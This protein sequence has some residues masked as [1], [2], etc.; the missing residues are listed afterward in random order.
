MMAPDLACRHDNRLP[1][2]HPA[3]AAL[4]LTFLLLGC[5]VLVPV[6]SVEDG[7]L[8]TVPASR[9]MS[10]TDIILHP[11]RYY[12][13]THEGGEV[14]YQD[15]NRCSAPRGS[16]IPGEEAW[17]LHLRMKDGLL[18]FRDG[19]VVTVTT[20]QELVFFLPEGEDLEYSPEEKGLYQD[21]KGSYKI[22]VQVL[23]TPPHADFSRSVRLQGR[24]PSSYC[25]KGLEPQLEFMKTLGANSITLEILMDIAGSSLTPDPET[26]SY[27]C[28]VD[29]T[30]R[31]HRMGLKVTWQIKYS[32]LDFPDTESF[33]PP[34][35]DG[36]NQFFRNLEIG[37][38]AWADLAGM[39]K[40]ETLIPA[41]G[42]TLLTRDE[43]LR[44]R[45]LRIFIG[46]HARFFGGLVYEASPHELE[47]L[48]PEFW[49]ACCD[50][51]GVR[52]DFALS[53]A[54]LPRHQDLVDA[55]SLPVSR[56]EDLFE[57]T[58]LRI[59]MID[60]PGYP[61]AP[62]CASAPRGV[63]GQEL[64]EDCQPIAY[65]ALFQTL[66][67]MAGVSIAG[68]IIK[69]INLPGERRSPFS[70]LGGITQEVLKNEW[71]KFGTH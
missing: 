59:L 27:F 65:R 10:H 46:L 20:P 23:T 37:L 40:V 15:T 56:M 5:T 7:Y 58:G 39:E 2:L 68:H 45:W 61:R 48:P 29:A 54:R 49:Q 53:Q 31:A 12:R 16:D 24:A 71:K 52:G 42:F 51:I 18:P 70:P 9:A 55:W 32:P 1:A 22:H 44:S 4:A 43:E 3:A 34:G 19:M 38:E 8:V 47:I 14:C 13:L 21:N 69:E 63:K 17:G 25:D 28:L 36:L 50:Q 11:E 64:D 60:A 35:E 66:G 30:R 62:A 57:K 67:P 26:T 6:E 41:G 33:L